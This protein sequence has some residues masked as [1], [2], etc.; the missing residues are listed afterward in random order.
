MN[1]R[2]PKHIALAI[3]SLHGGGAER[4]VVNLAAELLEQGNQVD[5]VL[6]RAEGVLMADVPLGIR[7]IDLGQSRALKALPNLVRYLRAERPDVMLSALDHMNILAVLARFLSGVM[8][9]VVV[10]AHMLPSNEYCKD[11]SIYGIFFLMLMKWSYIKASAVVGVS[12]GV[13]NDI[14]QT[15]QI[16]AH[17]LSYIYNPIINQ[18]LKKMGFCKINHRWFRSQ[19]APVIIAVGRLAIE[20]D[21][22][23]LIRAFRLV[24]N[25]RPAKLLILGEGEERANL[26]ALIALLELTDDVELAGFVPNP[27][28][29]MTKSEIYIL[30]SKREGFGNVVVEALALG[31]CVISTDCPGGPKEI[32][33][34]G[35]FG[36]MV[37]VGNIDAMAKA[38]M[39]TLDKKPLV[40]KALLE[41]HLRQFEIA[42]VTEKYIELFSKVSR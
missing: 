16:D 18:K 11:K 2:R 22:S 15:F 3:A 13:C 24:R 31:C 34:D 27:F 42:T 9:R 33:Q 10:S 19:K 28:A 36:L 41:N 30:S 29:F 5:L 35:M 37:P 7:I 38:L 26:Q 32:L 8:T 20:K 21:Y 25:E 39:S 12:K 1:I 4:V 14:M 6:V 40:D 17:N 23:T